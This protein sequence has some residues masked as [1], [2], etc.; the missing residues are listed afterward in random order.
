MSIYLDY[1]ATAP[2]RPEVVSWMTERFAAPCNASSVHSYGR[3]AKQWLEEARKTIAAAICV[4]PQ[5]IIF[6]A[7]GTEA[8]HMALRGIPGRTVLVSAAEHSSVLCQSARHIPVDNNGMVDLSKLDNMLTSHPDSLLSVML[9]NNEIGVIQPISEIAVLCKKYGALLHTDAVQALGKIPIDFGLLGCDMMTFSAHKMGGPVG[10][11]C[12]VV[13]QNIPI[14]PLLMGGGQELRRRAGTENVPAIAGFAKAVELMD[15]S[16]MQQL[17]GWLDT[18]EHVIANHGGAI[19]PG[20]APRLP[21]TSCI[22]MA[23]VSSEVQLMNF[24]LAGFAVSAG[25]ACSSGRIEASHVLS[26]MGLEKKVAS[27]AIRVS[28]GWN[29]VENDIISFTGQWI[30]TYKR[31]ATNS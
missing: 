16:H 28:G 12:L 13:K 29:T 3:K 7:S 24:D 14:Q 17:R 19:I 5:E 18:M 15:F 26:A 30:Q 25:A 1:N 22:A 8:N 31:L 6:T 9:A 21:H 11:A 2:V 4:F 27:A 10:A 20:E 23:N